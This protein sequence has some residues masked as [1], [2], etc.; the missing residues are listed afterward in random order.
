M[1]AT[2]GSAD[3]V[4][5]ADG[6]IA[7]GYFGIYLGYLFWRQEN[8]FLHWLTLV[9][10]PL[11]I[12]RVRAG[13]WRAAFETL[14]LRRGN[15]VRGTG[16]A[17]ALGAA[18]TV[19]QATFAAHAAEIRALFASGQALWLFPLATLAMLLLAG[20]TEEFFFRGFL[21]T[22]LER[23]TGTR[24]GAVLVASVLF[25]VYHLPYAYFNPSWPSAG[26][27]GAAWT[28][29]LGQGVPG[30]LVLGALF[31]VSRGNLVACIL[32]HALVNAGPVMTMIRF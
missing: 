9:A 28:A 29:A 2:T 24:W 26:D 6:W 15:L 18:I 14:G 4:R 3:R 31:V 17:V 20:F 21:Q 30:G 8:E 12:A 23:L 27:W 5:S 10:I 32:L 1:V 16:V 19:F 7:L 11:V 25:G 22:R 13:G